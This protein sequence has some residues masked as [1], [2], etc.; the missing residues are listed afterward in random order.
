MNRPEAAGPRPTA[1]PSPSH[2][3]EAGPATSE[4]DFVPDLA[5]IQRFDLADG[6]GA[7]SIYD[8]KRGKATFT[9]WH[10]DLSVVV[11]MTASDLRAIARAMTDAADALEGK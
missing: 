7:V 6:F 9:F 5:F 11:P 8:R 4:A 3:R 10:H 1:H 2:Q